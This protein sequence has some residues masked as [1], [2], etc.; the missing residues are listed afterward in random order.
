MDQSKGSRS[1]SLYVGSARVFEKAGF[2]R[3]AERRAGRPLV[4]LALR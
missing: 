4:R 1:L 3:V 2:V